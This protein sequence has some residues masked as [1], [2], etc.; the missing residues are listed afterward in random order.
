MLQES[1][2]HSMTTETLMNDGMIRQQ[3]N[4][5]ESIVDII[6]HKKLVLMFGHVCR[7]LIID[8]FYEGFRQG[9]R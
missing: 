4:R 8:C 2:K 6:R 1:A 3:V 7:M 5:K 9:A